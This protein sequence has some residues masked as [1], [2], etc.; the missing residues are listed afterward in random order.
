MPQ[1]GTES[2]KARILAWLKRPGETVQP[3]EPICRVSADG[4]IAEIVS[5]DAGTVRRILVGVGA[6]VEEGHSL[7]E[8]EPPAPAQEEVEGRGT[9]SREAPQH[10]REDSAKQSSHG[11]VRAS[12]ER[13]PS[14]LSPEAVK[15]E[16]PK[17]EWEPEPAPVEMARFRS[18]AVRRLAAEHGIDLS[19]VAGSGRGGR[20]TRDDVLRA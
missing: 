10:G 19:R 14:P 2:G 16:E 18:P 15:P 17:T 8:I 7:A 9:P 6:S 13:R 5:P 20:I 3:D 4:A 12:R 11:W 1:A